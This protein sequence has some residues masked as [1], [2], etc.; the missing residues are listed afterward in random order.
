MLNK[1]DTYSKVPF[2]SFLFPLSKEVI[3]EDKECLII[4]CKSLSKVLILEKFT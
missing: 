1:L 3:S 4:K 2:L